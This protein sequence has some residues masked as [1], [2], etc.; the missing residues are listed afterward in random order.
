MVY[1]LFSEDNVKKRCSK[2]QHVFRDLSSHS[3]KTLKTFCQTFVYMSLR[4][5]CWVVQ[6]QTATCNVEQQ[7]K[8]YK[9]LFFSDKMKHWRSSF[10]FGVETDATTL[11]FT[12][13]KHCNFKPATTD[14]IKNIILSYSNCTPSLI[15]YQL[16]C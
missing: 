7:K 6:L 13:V 15:L 10:I 8:K 4:N 14:E 5:V 16:S 9:V 2:R 3:L 12:G 1:Q 11:Q